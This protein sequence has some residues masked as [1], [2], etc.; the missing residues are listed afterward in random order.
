MVEE[1]P[2]HLAVKASRDGVQKVHRVGRTETALLEGTHKVSC[3]LG[4]STK[5]YLH[6][7]LGST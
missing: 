7:N 1:P 3:T 5:Q 2:E 6:W 4:P